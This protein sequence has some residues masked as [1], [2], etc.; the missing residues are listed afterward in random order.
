MDWKELALIA[1][2]WASPGGLRQPFLDAPYMI[3]LPP[4]LSEVTL[5]LSETKLTLWKAFQMRL[6]P[7]PAGPLV[8]IPSCSAPS[9]VFPPAPVPPEDSEGVCLV[10]GARGQ[11]LPSQGQNN[12]LVLRSSHCLSP[13]HLR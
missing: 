7:P 9:G 13:W 5:F 1:Q 6:V 3:L 11:P 8:L 4:R 12:D 10:R 2:V